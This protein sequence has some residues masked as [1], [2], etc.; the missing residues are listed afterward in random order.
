MSPEVENLLRV[1]SLNDT[2][3]FVLKPQAPQAP[4]AM[5]W[6]LQQF[7]KTPTLDVFCFTDYLFCVWIFLSPAG[8]PYDL[9]CIDKSLCQHGIL[10]GLF[11]A[12]Q[13][14]LDHDLISTDFAASIIRTTHR[15]QSTAGGPAWVASAARLQEIIFKFCEGLPE[16]NGWVDVVLATGLLLNDH[17][18]STKVSLN[19]HLL[20][21][22]SNLDPRWIYS[23]LR[24]VP[25]ED[26]A[27]WDLDTVTGIAHL[28]AALKYYHAPL[29][30]DHLDVLLRALSIRGHIAT[31]AAIL[32]S[33][34]SPFLDAQGD[35]MGELLTKPDAWSAITVTV[36]NEDDL[37][38]DA[39]YISMG[40]MIS[41]ADH[42]HSHLWKE[43]CSLIVISSPTT[44]L[45]PPQTRPL[46]WMACLSS[47]QPSA[48]YP[49]TG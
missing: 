17:R 48:A 45:C 30:F 16:T 35:I 21:E 2:G 38:L 1:L 3:E 44:T 36:L 5:R 11:S 29:K 22:P 4:Q 23:A 10:C 12:L 28:F 18:E 13:T 24:T 32:L 7:E 34:S 47:C 20:N 26:G 27:E 19:R 37:E 9:A 39:R 8:S 43:L 49:P 25:A 41:R 6:C 31:T 40:E 46:H 33:K 15:L 42:G 14:S